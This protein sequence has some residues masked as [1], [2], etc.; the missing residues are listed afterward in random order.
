VGTL[1]ADPVLW[2]RLADDLRDSTGRVL[3]ITFDPVPDLEGSRGWEVA[4]AVD[5]SPAGEG[6]WYTLSDDP[7][8]RLVSLS[9]YIQ[10]MYLNEE[11]WG[12][13]PLCPRHPTRPIWPVVGSDARAKW[14]C[15]ASPQDEA[16]IGR[17]GVF[18]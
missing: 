2:R 4:V 11:V 15:E 6:S 14:R 5:G 1:D 17:L 9:D 8:G 10:D 13:W 18:N 12:G 7:E 3:E 16:E